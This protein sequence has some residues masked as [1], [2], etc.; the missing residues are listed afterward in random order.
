MTLD[1]RFNQ[2]EKVRAGIGV[3]LTPI[4]YLVHL[5]I[6]GFQWVSGT[7]ATHKTLLEENHRLNREWHEL[8]ARL[9]KYD[10]LEAEN[11]RLRELLDSSVKID[12][13]VLIAEV[14][15]VEMDPLKRQI[16]INKGSQH[17]AFIGQTVID[18]LGV[19]GQITQVTP[20]TSTVMLITNPD[21]AIP[22]QVARNGIRSIAV[23]S[24]E[25][26]RLE[27]PYL[28][29]N[30][31]VKTGDLLITSGLG[32]RFP[33][34]YPVA[35]VYRVEQDDI[36]TFSNAYARP[37]AR[38]DRHREVLMVWQEDPELETAPDKTETG[39]AK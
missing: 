31:D 34:G 37:T 19:V 20:F 22:V 15:H 3:V 38:L 6:S 14:L 35:E 39:E 4:Q 8:R 11:M 5:P 30:A 28:A 27:L 24:Q 12:D 7:F 2:L 18:A 16:I 33:Y 17:Q 32:G 25:D 9:M 10:A 13:R 1:H 29:T 36:A 21:H 23:G 26:Y